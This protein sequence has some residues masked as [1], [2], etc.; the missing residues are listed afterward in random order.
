[1]GQGQ[2]E[3]PAYYRPQM[4]APD[5]PLSELQ[6]QAALAT[7]WPTLHV[8]GPDEATVESAQ[9]V[10]EQS[11]GSLAQ[12]DIIAPWDETDADE[13]WELRIDLP[14]LAA[15]QWAA[16]RSGLGSAG[17]TARLVAG[18]LPGRR[19]AEDQQ[20]RAVEEIVAGGLAARLWFDPEHGGV[21]GPELSSQGEIG[22]VVRTLE[23]QLAAQIDQVGPGLGFRI[24]TVR[25]RHSGRLGVLLVFSPELEHLPGNELDSTRVAIVRAIADVVTARA[26]HPALK[27]A[28]DVLWDTRLGLSF[29]LWFVAAPAPRF[30]VDA[31][32]APGAHPAKFERFMAGLDGLSEEL[33]IQVVPEPDSHE[34][35]VADVSKLIEMSGLDWLGALPRWLWTDSGPVFCPVW[36]A[37]E[38]DA[39][40]VAEALAAVAEAPTVYSVRAVP[41]EPTGMGELWHTIDPG[42]WQYGARC[43]ARYHDGVL[44]RDRLEP[45]TDRDRDPADER[46]SMALSVA[47]KG[48]PELPV[49][50]R[51]KQGQIGRAVV[52]AS[53]RQGLELRFE[54]PS[55]A[56]PV[57][58]AKLFRALSRIRAEHTATLIPFAFRG[59]ALVLRL[60]YRT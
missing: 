37:P 55:C 54:D 36:R 57:V 58:L 44:D 50:E 11:L 21:L 47:L 16:V 53:E 9:R 4:L 12:A 25:D 35:A 28:P 24:E 26:S 2:E 18:M 10:V 23:K 20:R 17:I 39:T 14:G 3:H 34:L 49:L 7:G 8:F 19:A 13:P 52:D 33:E 38:A 51:G 41:G 46:T 29:T 40:A 32:A 59:S 31:V 5:H 43:F 56:D 30:P 60:W 42:F 1:M 22:A 45:V 15:E 48:R 27:L 6:A